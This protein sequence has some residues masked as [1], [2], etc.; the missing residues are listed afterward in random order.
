MAYTYTKNHLSRTEYN[1]NY[2]F[3]NAMTPTEITYHQTSNNAPAINER[4]YLN[5]R[6]DKVY[7]SFHI[8]VDEKETIECLPLTVGA[9]ACGD[10]S[11]GAGNTKSIN[12]EIA[13]STHEDLNIRNAAI[14]NGARVIAK[15]MKD[16]NIPLNKVKS[17]YDR[18]KKNCPH[19]IRGRYGETKFRNLIQKYYDELNG[20][21]PA[22]TTGFKVGDK[23]KVKL[24]AM[25]YA[26][27]TQTIPSYVKG[28]EYTVGRIDNRNVVLLNEITSL[29][30]ISDVE[31]V[32]D[33][34][35]SSTGS[36]STS[37][38]KVKII[39]DELNI[40]QLDSFDSQVVGIVKKG[41]VFTIIQESNGLCKLKS[42]TGWISANNKYVQKLK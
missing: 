35:E 25:T 7:I 39:S 31:K 38:Y 14:D 34:S 18:S 13:R 3:G 27:S 41:E 23:V 2:K 33:A 1:L 26:N 17:H 15:L 8:V 11:T 19:D 22:T 9:W 6:T 40:R 32:F 10:G 30:K 36:N 20:S 12:V 28:S 4:N 16:Y 5:N 42:G 37:A 21:A 24:S 29:V